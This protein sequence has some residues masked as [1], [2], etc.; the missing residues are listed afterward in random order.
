M[1]SVPYKSFAFVCLLELQVHLY[2]TH[3][4]I[5]SEPLMIATQV[6]THAIGLWVMMQSGD[7]LEASDIHFSLQCF[8]TLLHPT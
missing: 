3:A 1:I 2:A 7:P 8:H 6:E 5:L 4:H